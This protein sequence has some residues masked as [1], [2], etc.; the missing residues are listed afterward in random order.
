VSA[1]SFTA[2]ALGGSNI[3]RAL[4]RIVVGALGLA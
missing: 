1:L 3:R 2:G 4:L